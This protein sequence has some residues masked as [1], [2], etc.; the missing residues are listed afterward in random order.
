MKIVEEGDST[1]KLVHAMGINIIK[2]LLD[3]IRTKVYYISTA[4]V[5]FIVKREGV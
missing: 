1:N 2:K 4:G 5:T 3:L